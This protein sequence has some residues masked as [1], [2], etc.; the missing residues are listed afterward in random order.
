MTQ[1]ADRWQG[2]DLLLD[3][4]WT[5]CRPMR[6][7]RQ[8]NQILRANVEACRRY[9]RY[10]QLHGRLLW[11]DG[12]KAESSG[13]AADSGGWSVKSGELASADNPQSAI[14]NPQFCV[15]P[16]ILD[17][18]PAEHPPLFTLHSPVGA[19]LFSYLIGALLL[20]IGLLLGLTWRISHDQQVVHNTAPQAPTVRKPASETPLVARITGTADCVWTTWTVD[21]GQWT[22]GG[23]A[24]IPNPKSQISNPNLLVPLGAKFNVTSGLMEITY[25]TGARVILQGPCT[26]EVE[27]SRGGFLSLGR[28]TAR[29]EKKGAVGSRQ[30][31]VEFPSESLPTAHYPLPT[32]RGSKGERTANLTLA[33][34][35]R[36]PTTSLAPRP[37]ARKSELRTPKSEISNPQSLIPNPLFSIRTPT[38][39]VTDLGTE[40]GVEVDRLVQVGRTCL[41]AGSNCEQPTATIVT[42]APSGWGFASR[43]AWKT[44]M[45]GPSS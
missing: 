13:A 4:A 3:R 12:L 22:V 39:I 1:C 8:L 30:S 36:E 6:T 14:D 34:N 16:I 23:E 33:Q 29:V 15:P 21:G 43:P 35:A 19:F 40:F 10:V 42:S 11:G 37:L 32:D 45:A 27:S 20:G 44:G 5:A 41:R 31:A 2:F 7:F 18:S 28:L 38:A 17:V 26:Y 24:Q 9:V 25:D